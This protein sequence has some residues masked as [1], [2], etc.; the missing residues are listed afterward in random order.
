MAPIS[1]NAREGLCGA[2]GIDVKFHRHLLNGAGISTPLGA[3]NSHRATLHCTGTATSFTPF[4]V[5]CLFGFVFPFLSI[6]SAS[7]ASVLIA[8][9]LGTITP[10]LSCV[11]TRWLLN[12]LIS[13]AEFDNSP[14]DP[15]VTAEKAYTGSRRLVFS[16]GLPA[17]FAQNHL[18]SIGSHSFDPSPGAALFLLQMFD[19][20]S[21][22]R[23]YLSPS[24]KI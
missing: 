1:Q 8:P 12:K 15:L 13:P 16:A 3:I 22:L 7:P 11:M 2:R 19:E 21:Q 23:L 4:T 9:V 18:R 6:V 17:Q 24:R 10:A 14:P 5:T 20:R